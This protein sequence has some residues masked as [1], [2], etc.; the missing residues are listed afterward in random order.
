MVM[1]VI[2]S[3]AGSTN[4]DA[5]LQPIADRLQAV[6]QRFPTTEQLLAEVDRVRVGC[7]VFEDTGDGTR[8]EAFC[9]AVQRHE[10]APPTVVVMHH[11][12]VETAVQVMR[13]GVIDVHPS[14][15]GMEKL[16][17]SISEALSLSSQ[18]HQ[19]VCRIQQ[20]AEQLDRLTDG[21][22]RVLRLVL[23]GSLNKRIA[24]QLE[25]SE[26]TVEARRKRIF[27]KMGTQSVAQLVR[28]IIETVGMDDVLRRCGEQ[29]AG[30][31]APRWL[32]APH[33]NLAGR[34]ARVDRPG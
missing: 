23:E 22:L 34:Y 19:V 3:I 25:I 13:R 17:E 14:T 6:H 29:V 11:P 7:I 27:E 20:V 24:N 2:L 4:L 9:E 32:P 31:S 18:V 1:G 8:S 12:N 16:E 30:P 33:W 26:R 28:S 21:E 15:I 10:T 5:V